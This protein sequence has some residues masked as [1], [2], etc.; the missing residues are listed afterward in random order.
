MKCFLL[1]LYVTPFSTIIV[2]SNICNNYAIYLLELL[3][4]NCPVEYEKI[5][6]REKH[7]D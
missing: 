4:D 6:A 3:L 5:S 1:I 2:T 7:C